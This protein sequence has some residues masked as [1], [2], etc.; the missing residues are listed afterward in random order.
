MGAR[1]ITKTK[2]EQTTVTATVAVDQRK[3]TGTVTWW[4]LLTCAW[5]P[6]GCFAAGGQYPTAIY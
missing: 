2:L 4:S 1:Q 5:F 3:I 6:G